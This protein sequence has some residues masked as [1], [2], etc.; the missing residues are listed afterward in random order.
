[1]LTSLGPIELTIFGF[2]ILIA[3]YFVGT[4]VNEIV[5]REG[6][7]V[8]GNMVVMSAGVFIGLYAHEYYN[9]PPK[10]YVMLALWGIAGAFAFQLFCMILKFSARR[11]GM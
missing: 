4:F 7:G 2:C 6:F 9:F 10:D 5:E 3:C 1:M 8:V 11:L